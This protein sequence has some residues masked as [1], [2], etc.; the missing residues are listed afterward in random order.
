MPDD[1]G[2]ADLV[3][4]LQEL[5]GRAELSLKSA[6]DLFGRIASTDTIPAPGLGLPTVV[7]ILP[8]D[9]ERFAAEF[10]AAADSP[11]RIRE[12]LEPFTGNRQ[13]H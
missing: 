3:F 10:H 7:I 5:A 9:A 6:G 13:P 11:K 2:F 12:A 8:A 4:R 1:V